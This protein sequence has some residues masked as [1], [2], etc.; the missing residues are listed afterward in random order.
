[1]FMEA[2]IVL[3]I[4][5]VL[6]ICMGIS[7]ELIALMFLALLDLLLL[8]IFVF[9]MYCLI[10]LWGGKMKTAR[11]TKI[12]ISPK[13]K[14]KTAFYQIG[15]QEYANAFPAEL[16]AKK[17]FYSKLRDK[18]VFL[19]KNGDVFDVYSLVTVAAGLLLGASSFVIMFIEI[20][21][22]LNM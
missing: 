3:A 17:L 16:L 11:F 4:I 18:K 12:D 8:A 22:A 9:F 2:L 19:C 10:K 20:I 6:L 5:L 13:S 14:F 7:Y 21:S 15:D 1:M